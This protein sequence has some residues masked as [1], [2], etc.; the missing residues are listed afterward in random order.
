MK[1]T[2]TVWQYSHSESSAYIEV[3]FHRPHTYHMYYPGYASRCRLAKV[4]NF[5]DA[6]GH[7][8]DRCINLW[9]RINEDK[10]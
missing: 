5:H 7:L 4:L 3:N 8:R 6:R 1:G 10:S 9:Y 2:I